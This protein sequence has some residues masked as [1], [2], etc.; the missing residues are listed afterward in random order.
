MGTDIVHIPTHEDVG[1]LDYAPSVQPDSTRSHSPDIRYSGHC[2][3]LP[4]D[5]P[6]TATATSA[7]PGGTVTITLENDSNANIKGILAYV[8]DAADAVAGLTHAHISI[9]STESTMIQLDSA[10]PARAHMQDLGVIF[11]LV[12]KLVSLG[13]L[14]AVGNRWLSYSL[15][16]LFLLFSF[17]LVTFVLDV[18]LTTYIDIH[19]IYNNLSDM[20]QVIWANLVRLVLPWALLSTGLLQTPL[21]R[22]YSPTTWASS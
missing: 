15:F 17:T 1:A 22:K 18:T 2:D 21:V 19:V 10:H 6:Q 8:V 16:S 20:L 9:F 13:V 5:S 4:P 12:Y 7:E 11:P 14:M 3:R